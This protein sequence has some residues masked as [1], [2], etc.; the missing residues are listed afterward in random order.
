MKIAPNQANK[1]MASTED[2]ILQKDYHEQVL[3]LLQAV[4]LLSEMASTDAS[5]CTA[6]QRLDA[7]QS[8]WK[9]EDTQIPQLQEKIQR[10]KSTSHVL[11]QDADC[12]VREMQSLQQE[13]QS[14][15]ARIETL[16]TAVCKLHKRNERLKHELEQ[17][18]QQRKSLVKSVKKYVARVK[19]DE[20]HQLVCHERLLQHGSI[21]DVP[22]DE[23][24]IESSASSVSTATSLVTDEGI[25]TVR[26]SAVTV[27][28]PV[29]DYDLTFP[30]G[31]KIGLQF[32]R[33]EKKGILNDVLEEKELLPFRNFKDSLCGKHHDHIYLVCGH[34]GFDRDL[35]TLPALG[36]RLVK[37]NGESVA[38]WTLDRIKESIKYMDC[39]FITMSFRNEPLTPKQKELLQQAINATTRKFEHGEEHSGSTIIL[40]MHLEDV[41]NRLTS[42]L[43]SA[44]SRLDSDSAVD[45]MNRERHLSSDS[46]ASETPGKRLSA[47]LQGARSRNDSDP[48]LSDRES[49]SDLLSSFFHSASR[50]R[51]D[52]DSVVDSS[53]DA[54]NHGTPLNDG[55]G[56]DLSSLGARSRTNSDPAIHIAKVESPSNEAAG[57]PPDTPPSQ[58]F[59]NSMM[60]M[61]TKFK[62][63]F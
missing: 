45:I 59:K 44:R 8:Q 38:N 5:P 16:E 15:N 54:V 18:K 60:T 12:H 17:Q 26:Y 51:F 63:L 34:Y 56:H 20:K 4:N 47:F 24:S 55:A 1:S 57:P 41:T 58:T 42:F 37:V 29:Q 61:G 9:L 11:Q 2:D 40:D 28:E 39:G 30:Q 7:L 19:E 13:L 3:A 62:S 27:E 25:A 22:E 35:N 49:S 31:S 50:V 14:R 43:Q 46:I 52:S 6:L 53:L 23:L 32:H 10:L 33:L 36:A 21:D 48:D